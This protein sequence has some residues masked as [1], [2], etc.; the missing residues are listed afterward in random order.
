MES[1]KF[2]NSENCVRQKWLNLESKV[3]W[4]KQEMKD[5]SS[6]WVLQRILVNIGIVI[7]FI[8]DHITTWSINFFLSNTDTLILHAEIH[9]YITSNSTCCI[10]E[11][12]Q[13]TDV[14][15][16]FYYHHLWTNMFFRGECFA[17]TSTTK[18]DRYMKWLWMKQTYNVVLLH[19]RVVPSS[20]LSFEVG[21]PDRY[22]V[23][24]LSPSRQFLA[25]RPRPSF[26]IFP[27]FSFD[28]I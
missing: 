22:F 3:I 13:L 20:N 1:I 23:V 26:K 10:Q 17:E 19:I 27:I 21:Y 25:I 24:F 7:F 12:F 11:T 14:C 2:L 28:S 4:L 5:V 9:N 6:F 18:P 16:Y 8:S 15:K